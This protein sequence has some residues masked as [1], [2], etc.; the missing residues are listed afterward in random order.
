MSETLIGQ[1]PEHWETLSLG[2]LCARGGGDIQTGPFG[3]Q[4][5]AS[6]YVRVGIPSVMPQNIGDNVII[7]DGIARISP[8]D[9][10]RLKRYLL[11]PGDIVY[12]RRGD[13]ERR[14]LVRAEQSGWLCGTGCLRIRLGTGANSRFLSYYLSH[15][16]VRSYIVRHA[17][18]ATMPN[19]NTQILSAVPVV[20]P[21]RPVQQ[22]IAVTLGALDDKIA[23][24]ERAAG[25]IDELAA[26]KLSL[27]LSK[28]DDAAGWRLV[29][30]EDIASINELTVRPKSS[31]H[32]RY[33]DISSVSRGRIAWPYLIAWDEA[34]NRARRGVSFGDTIWSTVRPG[35]RSYALVLEQDPELV[36]STGFAVITPT[37]IGPAY[38][39]S[40]VTRDEFVNYLESVAEGSAYPAVRAERFA[41][42]LVS[43]PPKSLLT[44][45]EAEVMPL[46]SRAH[47][48]ERETL[49]LAKLRDTLLP[50][51]ISGE[52]RIRDAERAVEERAVEESV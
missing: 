7:E 48:A 28:F 25:T 20:L 36:A 21:P 22:A 4:L 34:P 11:A 23:V 41:A 45:F 39:Y 6:D 50:K 12:S 3:S 52:L 14:A 38:L 37:R 49:V 33:V 13:V 27:L 51:L 2:E 16:E 40:V 26:A 30:L 32:L 42:A 1:I 35:R 18:G 29:R 10:K 5:H 46:R 19:L 15:P 31:G 8:E 47:A 43:L 44:D 24:N 17:I 9:A